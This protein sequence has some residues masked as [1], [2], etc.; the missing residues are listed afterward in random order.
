[1]SNKSKSPFTGICHN[2]RSA[3][4]DTNNLNAPY[5][6]VS[7]FADWL[8]V[9]ITDLYVSSWCMLVEMNELTTG[10]CSS[11]HTRFPHADVNPNIRA[12]SCNRSKSWEKLKKTSIYIIY[13]FD[14][15]W[16]IASCEV[17]L[18]EEYL[19]TLRAQMEWINV[20]NSQTRKICTEI[21]G[22][23]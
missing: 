17:S 4:R 14:S 13:L 6:M 7:V 20:Q 16:L 18:S 22:K 23:M 1:M 21:D 8:V 12:S 9:M 15:R 11:I 3:L 5:K 10:I 2:S 19:K